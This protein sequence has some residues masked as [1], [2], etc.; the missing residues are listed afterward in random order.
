[1]PKG[2]E[3]ILSVELC[4]YSATLA[5]IK[6][7]IFALRMTFGLRRRHLI[8]EDKKEANTLRWGWAI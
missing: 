8:V 7:K 4:L 5:Y 2:D 1:M 6:R 3:R